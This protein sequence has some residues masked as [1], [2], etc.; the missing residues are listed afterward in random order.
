VIASF[1]AMACSALLLLL[2]FF[3]A[4]LAAG[5]PLGRFAWGGG[6]RVLPPLLRIGSLASLLLYALM[7]G[8]MLSKAAVIHVV[9]DGVATIGAWAVSAFCLTG[10]AL[11]A[12]SRSEPERSAMVPLATLLSLFSLLVALEV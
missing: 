10:I 1:A 8:V 4:A 11:N 3:Q 5:A 7:A 9:P 12:M 2:A 6:H